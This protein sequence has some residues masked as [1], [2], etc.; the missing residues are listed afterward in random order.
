MR[1]PMNRA[2]ALAVAAVVVTSLTAGLT[3]SA[4]ASGSN[5]PKLPHATHG[6]QAI[7]LL[8]DDLADAAALNGMSAS[9]L[10]QVL[11]QDSTAW[12]DENAHMYYVEPVAPAAPE[13]SSSSIGAGVAPYPLNQTFLLHSRPTSLHTIYLDFD[14]VNVSNTAWNDS[15]GLPAGDYA[16]YS[17]DGSATFNNAE[18][19]EIQ[20]IWQRVAEDYAPFDVDVTTEDP[21]VAAIDR[22]DGSDLE[23]GTRAAISDDSTASNA[24]C[25]S[26]CGGI[27]YID[28]F[29]RAGTG[30]QGHLYYQPAW[31]FGHLL[32]SN[33]TKDIAE[34]VSHE[35][36]HN[37]GL[38]HDGTSSLSYYTGHAMWA[39]IMGVGYNRPVVQWSKGQYADANNLQDDLS[40]IAGNDAR[41]RR[42]G[43][44]HRGHGQ[45]HA[46]RPE[47][48]HVRGR[49]GRLPP[50]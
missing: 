31:V 30:F 2:A 22:T 41:D 7:Q 38:N 40:I 10:R 26:S 1:I 25:S 21:G 17:L 44:R 18:K 14:G 46:R 3:G 39:P 32:A 49:Q 27:A 12:L 34:A 24:V 42:R 4:Q 9:Q 29:D 36:G 16:G 6:Q 13:G 37:F 35:V 47:A 8:G 28:V 20:K 50:G 19:E 11:R 23:F 48:D 45:Q 5:E 33:D 15:F 43:G